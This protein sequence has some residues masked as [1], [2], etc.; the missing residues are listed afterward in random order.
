MRLQGFIA[1]AVGAGLLCAAPLS[2]Q[3]K[4]IEGSSFAVIS[5]ANAAE[6]VVSKRRAYRGAVAVYYHPFCGGPYVGSGWNGGS[7]Y[8]GPWMDLRC[9]G[10]IPWDYV[11]PTRWW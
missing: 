6:L 2:V 11:P 10:Q 5:T 1:A 4:G 7:Y 3:W 9:Y 8:G